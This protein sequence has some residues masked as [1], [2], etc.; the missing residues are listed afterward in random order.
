MGVRKGVF[1]SVSVCVIVVLLTEGLAVWPR[2]NYM[3][4]FNC[5]RCRKINGTR[6]LKCIVHL[7]EVFL[8]RQKSTASVSLHGTFRGG[9]YSCL[10]I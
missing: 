7:E 3:L 8:E 1:M 5:D 10:V 2:C 6:Y 4:T 9:E